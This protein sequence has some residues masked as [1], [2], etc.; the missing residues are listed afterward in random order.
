VARE[1]LLGVHGATPFGLDEAVDVRT[2]L[3]SFTIWGAH[4]LFL[5]NEIGSIEP[6]KYADLAVWDTD[7]YTAP[8][9]ALKEM[10]CLLTLMNGR[11]VHEASDSPLI[12]S[13]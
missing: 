8:T 11:I 4:Q 12:V 9:P 13:R 3:R 2:A 5:E 10:R 7:L 6:G 1:T